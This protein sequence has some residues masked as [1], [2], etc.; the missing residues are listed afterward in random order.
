MLFHPSEELFEHCRVVF[1]RRD[2][3][4]GCNRRPIGVSQQYG[5]SSNRDMV[6]GDQVAHVGPKRWVVSRKSGSL[7]W[8][9]PGRL[10]TTA[11]TS[12]LRFGARCKCHRWKVDE[13]MAHDPSRHL[14]IT[15]AAASALTGTRRVAFCGIRIG[16]SA[17]NNGLGLR[18]V[19]PGVHPQTAFS[20]ISLPV[21][22]RRQTTEDLRSSASSCCAEP[23]TQRFEP[24][25]TRLLHP[26]RRERPA[27]RCSHR[28]P[29]RRTGSPMTC[30][31]LSTT[32]TSGAA[33][34]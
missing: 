33:F 17:R 26:A 20:V 28:S 24:R 4:P 2:D 8:E 23:L 15:T 32:Q 27:S 21:L 13:Q 11:A 9:R 10:A 5:H 19:S 7:G 30:S 1:H 16:G 14:R 29:P 12:A 18:F 6:A 22:P 25:A 31:P 34:L 3:R